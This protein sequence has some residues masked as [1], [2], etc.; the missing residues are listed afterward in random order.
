MFT[1]VVVLPDYLAVVSGLG[2]LKVELSVLVAHELDEQT[3]LF[4]QSL[5]ERSV[6][7]KPQLLESFL[8]LSCLS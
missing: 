2:E 6:C 8:E 5:L 3:D 4:L 7:L 1:F